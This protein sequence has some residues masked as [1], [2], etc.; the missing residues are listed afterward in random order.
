MATMASSSAR[1]TG[2]SPSLLTGEGKAPWSRRYL[3]DGKT[4]AS[5]EEMHINYREGKGVWPKGEWLKRTCGY[6]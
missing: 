5:Y 4:R 3:V 1:S 2:V 6:S